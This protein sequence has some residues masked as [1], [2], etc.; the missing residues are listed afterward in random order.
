MKS[1]CMNVGKLLDWMNGTLDLYGNSRVRHV[2]PDIGA[3]ESLSDPGFML[4]VK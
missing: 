2:R 3:T 4:I 1:P